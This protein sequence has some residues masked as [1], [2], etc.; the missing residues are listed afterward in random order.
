MV[1]Q[2][3]YTNGKKELFQR[4][5]GVIDTQ[6]K[7]PLGK[8]LRWVAQRSRRGRTKLVILKDEDV[9]GVKMEEDDG[10]GT[11]DPPRKAV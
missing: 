2:V 6:A 1:T 3:T 10:F 9:V 7:D 4:C 5:L 11:F 8:D